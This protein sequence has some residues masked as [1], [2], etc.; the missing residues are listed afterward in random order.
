M[1]VKCKR[2]GLAAAFSILMVV[3]AAGAA[4][5]LRLIEAARSQNEP[6]VR[7]LLNQHVD[8]NARS[9]DGSTALLWA[10]H[11]NALDTAILLIRSG[12]DV[13][14][15]NDLRMTPLS[16]ACTN[17]SAALV[18]L[19]LKSGANP[20]TSIATGV[21]PIMTCARTGNAEAVRRL[22]A[23]GVDLN[24]KEPAQ[25][26]T[27]LMWA[28]AE[29]HPDVV[30]VL[31]EAKANANARTKNGF[32]ALH[33]AAREGD[34]ESAGLLLAAG[35]KIDVR[36]QPESESKNVTAG[37]FNPFSVATGAQ[38]LAGFNPFSGV[39]GPNLIIESVQ[40]LAGRRAVS[41]TASEGAT[42][43]LVATV[44]AE[45]PMALFLLEQGANPNI[46]DAGL[47]ALHWAASTWEGGTANPVYGFDEPMAGISDRA[48]KLQLVKSLLAHGAD[49]NARMTRKPA[50]S[51]G[52]TDSTGAT[53]FVLASSVD[54]VEMMRL[55]L[56][57]G[58]DP[59]LMTATN[60]TAVMAAAGINHAIGESAVT[61]QQAV[62]AVNFLLGLGL[63]AGGVT[64]FNE[65][66][67]FGPAYRGWN[68]LLEMLIEK[69]AD[70]NVVS[71]AG[72]TPWLAAS[73]FGDRLGGVL[74]NKAG[75]DILAKHGADPKLGRPCEAQTK[76]R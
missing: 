57:A 49:P 51:G 3:G 70:V 36:S 40:P 19:L 59:K 45:V 18:D 41:A 58:A 26:Q 43:L 27:A 34:I 61:E 55:L 5:D 46:G 56:A 10:A 71:K 32:T 54:D 8:V 35:V 33:F 72:V 63:S 31:I 64:T 20:S 50:F 76:C 9:G 66:V 21:P 25:G 7:A 73:G 53:P 24:A 15:A 60:V 11:W 48:A 16:E 44:R 74:Y 68:T 4:G 17:G 12:A 65:N 6:Q 62:D 22:I 2:P 47:T 1:H 37:G 67:L 28:A 30:R 69:G 14:M 38:P 13:N 29:H 75:A 23:G 52:Y 39:P 42:P